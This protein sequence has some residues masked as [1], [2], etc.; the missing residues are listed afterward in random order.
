MYDVDKV[1]RKWLDAREHILDWVEY[2]NPFLRG[3]GQ[4][5]KLSEIRDDSYTGY[6]RRIK[7]RALGG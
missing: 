6:V 2:V 4:T 5:R 1:F 7:T 3:N